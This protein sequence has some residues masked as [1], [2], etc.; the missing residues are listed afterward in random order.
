MTEAKTL[1][2][3]DH[4]V[5]K[6]LS[7]E[8]TTTWRLFDDK[9]LRVGDHLVFINKDTG[10]RF[11]EADVTA[12]REKPLSEIDEDDFAEGH[13]RYASRDAMLQSYRNY[14]GDAVDWH[15][16]I[17]LINFTFTAD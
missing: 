17:K 7:G 9:D 14:Y 5:S 2:F 15:T 16:P 4:L 11:G 10:E 3:K 13:E 6:I 1:K 12:M 8:K